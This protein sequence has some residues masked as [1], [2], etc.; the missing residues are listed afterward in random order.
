MTKATLT[1]AALCLA[2]PAIGPAGPPEPSDDTIRVPDTIGG[3]KLGMKL[4]KADKARGQARQGLHE[5]C[6]RRR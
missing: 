4:K 3:V 1:V 6:H 2:L 5:L